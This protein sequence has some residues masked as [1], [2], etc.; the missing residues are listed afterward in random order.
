MCWCVGCDV[1]ALS[2]AHVKSVTCV[3][4]GTSPWCVCLSCVVNIPACAAPM[5]VCVDVHSTNLWCYSAQSAWNKLQWFE[6]LVHTAGGTYEYLSA[7]RLH[8]AGCTQ[9]KWHCACSCPLADYA[10]KQHAILLSQTK[11]FICC[12]ECSHLC[13]HGCTSLIIPL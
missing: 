9:P 4:G 1:F 5:V 11:A 8:M 7:S 12:K 6:P 3:K 2:S 13:L 10:A